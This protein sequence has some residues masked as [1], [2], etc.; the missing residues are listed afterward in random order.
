MTSA[1]LYVGLDLPAR[2][3]N[4]SLATQL[5]EVDSPH[6]GFKINLDHALL[7]GETYIQQVVA[8]RRP[9]FVDLKMNNGPR[10]MS[11]IVAWLGGLGV[12]HTNVW[13]HSDN[14]LARTISRLGAITDRPSILAVTFY[15]RWDEIYAQ[16]HHRMGLEELVAHWARTAVANGADGVILPAPMLSAVRDLAT[17]R[18]TPGIRLDGQS[19]TSEQRH[20]ATPGQAIAAGADMLVASS[21]IYSDPEPT[22]ALRQFLAAM[23]TA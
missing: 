11:T 4:L 6:F 18:L 7:W 16:R 22:A 20:V 2:A 10:T 9:V 1:L 3:A 17:T 21:P 8:L 12:A 13:A 5:C 19:T 14:N 15:T 23:Q